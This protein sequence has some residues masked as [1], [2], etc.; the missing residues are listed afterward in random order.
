MIAVGKAKR[1]ES[2]ITT[3]PSLTEVLRER[4]G[5]REELSA[6]LRSKIG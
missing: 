2:E 6:G 3:P 1:R 5:H 4:R